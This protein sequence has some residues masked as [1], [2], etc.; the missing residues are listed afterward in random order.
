LNVEFKA[1][2]EKDVRAVKDKPLLR[3]VA[4]LI[5]AVGRAQ[6]PDEVGN[7]KKLKGGGGYFRVRIGAYRVGLIVQGET[8]TFVRFLNRGEIYR[9]F[10]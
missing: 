8:V 9:Y 1:S 10:P 4:E 5:E 6:T 7:L 2:F 3:R